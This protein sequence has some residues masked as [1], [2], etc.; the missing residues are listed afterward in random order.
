[1]HQ[2]SFVNVWEPSAERN[3]RSLNQEA[4]ARIEFSFQVEDALASKVHQKWIDEAMAGTFKPGSIDRLKRIAAKAK[5]VD[6][7]DL[8]QR[9]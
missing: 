2:K 3:Y 6:E 9:F 4:L 1:V 7:L 8:Q 5:Q